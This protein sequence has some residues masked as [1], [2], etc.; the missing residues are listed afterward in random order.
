MTVLPIAEAKANLEQALQDYA[1]S[2]SGSETT[3]RTDYAL[4]VTAMDYDM[5]T[6]A[7]YYFHEHS[8]PIHARAGLVFMMDEEVK[9]LNREEALA[10]DE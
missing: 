3:V 4:V 2:R 7:T 8:G 9:M 5:P 1:Q 6:S 10:N